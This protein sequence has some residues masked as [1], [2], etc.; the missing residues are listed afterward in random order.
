MTDIINNLP[1][2]RLQIITK[3]YAN[4]D[5]QANAK[6]KNNLRLH[7]FTIAMSILPKIYFKKEDAKAKRDSLEKLRQIGEDFEQL[8]NDDNLEANNESSGG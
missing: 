6:I 3:R 5:D 1:N 4:R 2:D 8:F 7:I